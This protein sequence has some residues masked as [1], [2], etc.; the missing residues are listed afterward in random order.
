MGGG[1]IIPNLNLGT[2]SYKSDWVAV[3]VALARVDKYEEC[4]HLLVSSDHCY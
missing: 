4:M 3:N 1:T 2:A